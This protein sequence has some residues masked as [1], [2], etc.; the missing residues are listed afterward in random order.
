MRRPRVHSPPGPLR[1]ASLFACLLGLFGASGCNLIDVITGREARLLEMVPGGNVGTGALD[2]WLTMEFRDY[3]EDAD[4]RDVRV[5]F[6]SAA[7][8]KPAEFDWR[9]IASN[10]VKANGTAFGS[11]YVKAQN[12]TPDA[13]PPLGE[14]IKVRFPLSARDVIEDAP[15]TLWLQAELY[16]G[17]E[18]QHSLR[19]TIEH[20][21]SRTGDTLF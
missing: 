1:L 7:L 21:Y 12:T 10:D 19:R 5:R 6:Y 4:L 3:P 14:P 2:C 13:P 15:S 20:V 17:G 18:V 9:Y 11:G 16:W 8:K